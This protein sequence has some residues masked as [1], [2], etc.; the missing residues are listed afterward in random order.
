MKCPHDYSDEY[1]NRKCFHS[2]ILETVVDSFMYF[3]DICVGWP[4]RVHDARVLSNSKLYQK[5]EHFGT[6]FADG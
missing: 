6:C 5:A 2:V 3:T 4:G 1:Y